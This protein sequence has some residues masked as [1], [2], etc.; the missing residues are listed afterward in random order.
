M[1]YVLYF[2][3]VGHHFYLDQKI[4]RPSLQKDLSQYLGLSIS[5]VYK[6]LMRVPIWLV[7]AAD[8]PSLAQTALSFQ[9]SD[10]GLRKS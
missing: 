1:A 5:G 10:D 7:E 3:I 9:D 4:W 6:L 2:G 8:E